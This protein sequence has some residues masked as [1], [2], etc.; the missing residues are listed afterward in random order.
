MASILHGLD[1]ETGDEVALK[2]VRTASIHEIAALEREITTLRR[3]RH[4]GVVR[5]VQQGTWNG[6]PWMAME[7]LRGRTLFDEVGFIWTERARTHL[8]NVADNVKEDGRPLG[9]WW[10]AN[11]PPDAA[12]A[13]DPDWAYRMQQDPALAL[14]T[15]LAADGHL[16]DALAHVAGLLPTLDYLHR[17]RIVHGDL[18]PENVFLGDDGRITL[19]D[20]GLARRARRD[21]AL[22][23]ANDFCLGTMEYAAPEQ[24]SGE[25][26]DAR[27]DL[28]SLGCI[29]YELV[30]GRRPFEGHS[31][32][33]IAEKHLDL[34]PVCP[35]DLVSGLAWELDDLIIDLLAKEPSRR[36]RDAGAV[37]RRLDRLMRN[38][39]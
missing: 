1:A 29:L 35:S 34:D 28:Y 9:D 20:F 5:F 19:L 22:V 15:H 23:D 39:R 17:R 32:D 31:P 30:T 37:G 11:A 36:P 33:E 8:W 38:A 12:E 18:K 4:R 25:P 16:P 14:P 27:A 13:E 6:A 26:V 10:S 3:L 2:T 21:D 7:L 24:I